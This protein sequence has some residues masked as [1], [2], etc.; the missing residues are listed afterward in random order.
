MEESALEKQCPFCG[1]TI[2]AVAVRCKHC[3]ADLKKEADFDRGV[4]AGPHAEPA[5]VAAPTADFEQRFLEFAYKT[6]ARINGPSVAYALKIPI[7]EATD[8]LEDLA[9]RDVLLREVDDEGTVYFRLPGRP[10]ASRAIV[11]RPGGPLAKAPQPVSEATA[12]VGLLLN[13]TMPGVGSLV[14]GRTSDGIIQLTMFVVGFPLCFVLIGFPMIVAAWVW[15]LVSGIR[16]VND[17]K[18]A[19]LQR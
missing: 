10:S 15:G 14:A 7:D 8:K 12:I 3:Q 17:A 16:A 4:A 18:A 9:A 19:A 11:P 1:E 13:L 6:T 2:K 5:P